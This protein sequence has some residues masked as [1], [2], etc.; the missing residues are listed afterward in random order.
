VGATVVTGRVAPPD[1]H[2][3]AV[4]VARPPP[5][6]DV[7]GFLSCLGDILGPDIR[8]CPEYGLNVHG[9]RLYVVPFAI[10]DVRVISGRNVHDRLVAFAIGRAHAFAPPGA[11][12]LTANGRPVPLA[13]D[14]TFSVART[15]GSALELLLTTAAGDA[16]IARV[17]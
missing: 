13:A 3:P 1:P 7:A 4:F 11:L 14:G 15:D 10:D 12:T 5:Q 17:P 8:L 2:V 6:S 9:K 16:T